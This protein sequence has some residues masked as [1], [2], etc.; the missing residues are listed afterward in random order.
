MF[1]PFSK[2]SVQYERNIGQTTNPKVG[3]RNVFILL[4]EDD[5][6]NKQKKGGRDRLSCRLRGRGEGLS[7]G[8]EGRG[9]ECFEKKKLRERKSIGKEGGFAGSRVHIELE[10]VR[11]GRDSSG[12]KATRFPGYE[13]GMRFL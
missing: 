8:R 4:G 9:A 1:Q 2:P 10:R 11:K 5:A 13:T 3:K 7:A 6:F 12:G